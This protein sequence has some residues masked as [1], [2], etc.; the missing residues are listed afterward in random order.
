MIL[1]LAIAAALWGLGALM[2]APRRARAMM[3]GA[4]ILGVMLIQITLPP[5]APLRQATGE[6]VEYWLILLATI[7]LVWGYSRLVRRLRTRAATQAAPAEPEPDGQLSEAELNRSMRHIV[8]R[9][10]GGPGQAALKRARVLVIGAGG[11]GSPVLLY[12]GAAGVG[13]LGVI[14]DDEVSLTN[15]QRQVIH[16][17]TTLGRP[18]VFSAQSRLN[19]LNPH[20][21]LRPYNRR[22]TEEIAEELFA[23]YDLIIDG[24]DNFD[25]RYLTN[26]TCVAL[27]KPLISGA[28]TQWEG[29]VSLFDPANGGPCYQCLFPRAPDPGLAP[30]CAEAGVLGPLPGIIGTIMASE[31][32]KHITGAGETL[33]SRLMLHDALHAETRTIATRANP[34][35]PTCQGRGT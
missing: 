32:V 22:L 28:L 13:T 18:K 27:S 5:E 24:T 2:G 9:E 19:A 4:L 35:C 6:R 25:T 33:R 14:D 20:L 3:I 8:L 15:L 10:I 16:D 26:R 23:D 1:I 7:A 17:E 21:V 11:L 31:A 34:E 29:Q 30:S 12:L